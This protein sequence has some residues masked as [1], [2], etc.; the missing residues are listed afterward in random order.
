LYFSILA[1]RRVGDVEKL[2]PFSIAYLGR[3]FKGNMGFFGG[4]EKKSHGDRHRDARNKDFLDK[5]GYAMV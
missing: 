2:I 4:H 3:F 5:W 1:C